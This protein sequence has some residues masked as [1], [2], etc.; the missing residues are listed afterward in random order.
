MDRRHFIHVVNTLAFGSVLPASAETTGAARGLVERTNSIGL[1]EGIRNGL[2]VGLVGVGGIGSHLLRDIAEKLPDKCR[3]VAINTHA[4][5]LLHLDADRKIRICDIEDEPV[6]SN[7]ARR[8]VVR[9][10]SRAAIPEIADA[11]AGLDMV[12]L[13]AGMGGVAGTVISPIVAQ[14]LREQGIF[15]L[16]LPILPF[17]W[18][19]QRRNKIARYGVRELGLH[20]NS[21]LPISNDA[22]V[23]VADESATFDDIMNQIAL[24]IVQLCRSMTHMVAVN[25]QTSADLERFRAIVSHEGYLAFG[26]GSASGPNRAVIAT[27]HA[28]DHPMLGQR[29]LKQA[30]G[31]LIAVEAA[32]QSLG[33]DEQ[34]SIISHL[35]KH[36][37]PGVSVIFSTTPALA[38]DDN[39]RVSVLAS[40]IRDAR[41]LMGTN[42]LRYV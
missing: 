15:T 7:F 14:V 13:V 10:F 34:K 21:L 17:D 42:L 18:E 24:G 37:A 32:P 9:R 20:V 25:G 6:Q 41:A 28:I 31:V 40:G 23:Q 16:G 26:Y 30:S 3:T 38:G 29:S 35:M 2:R 19:G 11:V 1:K 36:L 39:L 27:T 5:S 4:N 22:F 33:R 12:L 8:V